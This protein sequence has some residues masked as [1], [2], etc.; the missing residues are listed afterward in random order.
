MVN[1]LMFGLEI[2]KKKRGN[3]NSGKDSFYKEHHFF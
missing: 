2:P 1:M 3:T